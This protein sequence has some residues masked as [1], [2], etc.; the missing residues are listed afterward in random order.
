V[1]DDYLWDR[2]GRDEEI[3]RLERL[4]SPLAYRTGAPPRRSRVVS[5]V[6]LGVAA[7]T[8]LAIAA[9][10]RG[11][12]GE[13]YEVARDRTT[14]DLGDVGRV[15]LEP[16]SRW[17]V[18]ARGPD[19]VKLRLQFGTM[20]ASISADAKPRLF[21]VETPSTTCVDLGCVY[22]L[23]VDGDG[24]S[25]VRVTLGRVAFQ[26]GAREVYV[27]SGAL[28][29]AGR[30]G[31]GLPHFEDGSPELAAAIRAFDDAPTLARARDVIARCTWD[32]D[33]LT[34]W[35]LVQNPERVVAEAGY[36]ALAKLVGEPEGVPREALLS[37]DR[38]AVEKW[39]N[40]LGWW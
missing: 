5:W 4:M 18:I 11:G 10:F 36:D 24:R 39:K 28:C 12:P 27:P 19:L 22:S 3:E 35:H 1:S 31:P 15:E 34:L 17:R 30:R 14:I 7:A 26:D 2:T 21:Q 32:R 8:L 38:E 20:R 33:A 13:G 16:D 6:P 25:V 9:L 40:R 29:R 23:T 37:G